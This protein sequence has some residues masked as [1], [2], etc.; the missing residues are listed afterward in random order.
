MRLTVLTHYTRCRIVRFTISSCVYCGY[1]QH[2]NEYLGLRHA[3]LT[4]NV[5]AARGGVLLLRHLME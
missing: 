4:T 3:T 5:A 2:T 1:N